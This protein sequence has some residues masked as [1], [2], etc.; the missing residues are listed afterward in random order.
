MFIQGLC[1]VNVCQQLASSKSKMT[2]RIL[3]TANPC[4][5]DN[6]WHLFTQSYPQGHTTNRLFFIKLAKDTVKLV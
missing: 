1:T 4:K 6:L 3:E 5:H 2:A